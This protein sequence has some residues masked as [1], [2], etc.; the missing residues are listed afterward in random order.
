MPTAPVSRASLVYDTFGSP[1]GEPLLLIQGLGVQ[2]IGW[3]AEFCARLAARGYY[4]IRFDNRDI[5]LSSRH[6]A[7]P[8]TLVRTLVRH[9]M[10]LVPRAPYLIGDMAR[11]SCE[12]LDHLGLESAHLVGVSMGGIIAQTMAIHHPSRVRSLCSVMSSA[13]PDRA[14]S[15]WR[16]IAKLLY[17]VTDNDPAHMVDRQLELLR[18]VGSKR[19]L[20]LNEAR[21]HFEKAVARCDDRSGVPRQLGAVLACPD[22]RAELRRVRVPT[23]VIH[24]AEDPL[25]PPAAGWDTAQRATGVH[26]LDASDLFIDPLVLPISTGMDEDRRSALELVEGVRRI[27]EAFPDVQIVCGLSNVSFGLKPAARVVL[28]SVFLHE[29]VEAG[30]TSA[31]VHASKIL[32]LNKIESEHKRVALHLVYDRRAE[33]AGGTGVPDAAE[34]RREEEAV[35]SA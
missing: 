13:A 34:E 9:R 30:L 5:G 28:N 17:L 11:D 27:G 21:A 32:P 15:N 29:L 10:G 33:S 6:A 2:L 12:L 31:I 18:L 3:R 1:D 26:G 22:R 19:Y 14:P 16:R 20:D 4:V 8:L 23:I 24:G 7:R 35:A 25:I